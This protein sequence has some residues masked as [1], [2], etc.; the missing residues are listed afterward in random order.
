[1]TASAVGPELALLMVVL[2]WASTFIVTKDALDEIKPLAFT[3]A[4]YALMLVLAFGVLAVRG[5]GTNR[6]RVWALHRADVPRF[7]VAG[8]SGYTLY[9]LGFV[10]GLDRTS[11][12]SS[13]L[14]IA[15]VPLFTVL[16]LTAGGERS[17]RLVWVGMSIAAI[18]VAVFLAD[19]RDA[20]GLAVAGDLLSLG[21]AVVFAIYGIAN[22]PLAQRYPPETYT[23]YT[24]V[25][26]GGP[27]LLI[28]APAAVAQDW[29]SIGP[30]GWFAIVYMA[31]F[32]V[33]VAYMLWNWAIGRRGVAVATSASLLVPIVS[34]AFSAL[35]FDEG[36]G[37]AKLLGAALVLVGLVLIRYRK[38]GLRPR[39]RLPDARVTVAP[40]GETS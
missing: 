31:I 23:A 7:I 8:V 11:P 13:S 37:P 20:G 14:L 1:M 19:K 9:Q 22:R 10:L 21:A 32:P 29:G 15:M 28:C 25:A 4:R 18:G 38:S 5:R 33:Y 16:M 39:P 2:L 35:I 36:F 12:F 24:L 3:F 34:G 6:A 27:L 17:P 30:G 40:G 26:G